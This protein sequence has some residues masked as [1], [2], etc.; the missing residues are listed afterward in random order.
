MML[1]VHSTNAVLSALIQ[2]IRG[3]KI[4]T[5]EGF[6]PRREHHIYFGS[7]PLSELILQ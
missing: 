3:Q 2:L 5:V 4:Q 6:L 1:L 7:K